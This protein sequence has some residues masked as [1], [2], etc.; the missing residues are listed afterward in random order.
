[1]E[2]TEAAQMSFTRTVRDEPYIA[3]M[4]GK[5][6]PI[7]QEYQVRKGIWSPVEFSFVDEGIWYYHRSRLQRKRILVPQTLPEAEW[8]K[9]VVRI[10]TV[11]KE[12]DKLQIK[13]QGW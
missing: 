5:E 2:S 7:V 12:E 8:K 1:M 11:E 13:K 4:G 9:W 6:I 10:D 3:V